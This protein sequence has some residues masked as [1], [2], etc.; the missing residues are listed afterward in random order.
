MAD[1]MNIGGAAAYINMAADALSSEADQIFG[2]PGGSSLPGLGNIMGDGFGAT[3]AGN[4]GITG[5]GCFPNIG[6]LIYKNHLGQMSGG[7]LQGEQFNQ[8]LRML[9]AQL[10]GDTA[11]AAD[12][13][14]KLG[15]IHGEEM[16]RQLGD[17]GMLFYKQNLTNMTTPQ[18]RGEERKQFGALLRA[19]LTGD[20]DGARQAKEKLS[21]VRHELDGRGPT[22]PP[23]PFPFPRP[24]PLPFPG[25]IFET[26]GIK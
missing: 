15:L 12:A 20:A 21:A 18:L 13:K 23:L 2:N 4:T 8:E 14:H 5:G 10:T 24:Q 19:E 6:D 26:L 16:K 7:Q 11:G 9:V 3:A 22:F 25:P 17:L 1:N